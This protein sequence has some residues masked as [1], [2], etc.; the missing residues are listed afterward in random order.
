[1]N[2]YGIINSVESYNEALKRVKAAQQ[3]YATYT[4]ESQAGNDSRRVGI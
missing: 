2:E 1:M 3:K 4:Q